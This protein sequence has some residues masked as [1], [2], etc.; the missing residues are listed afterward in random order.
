MQ[1][2][3]PLIPATALPELPVT[4]DT[5]IF[6]VLE[7]ELQVLLV[8]RGE[9]KFAGLWSLPG[10][11]V[12]PNEALDEAAI[13]EL[14]EATGVHDVYLEQ[15]YTFGDP[16][17]DTR[18][19]VVSVAYVALL[20]ADRC[21]LVPNELEAEARW[22]P[23]YELPDLAF[24]HPRMI[25]VAIDRVRTKLEYTT[26]G[27]QL[28]SATFT[29]GELQ[30]VYEVILDRELDKRN[31]RRRLQLLDLVESTGELRKEGPGRPALLHRFSHVNF[32][33]LRDR[34]IHTPF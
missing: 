26:I 34:G 18:G 24:D 2:P 23:A 17:R 1:A 11:F 5:V 30:R 19:R 9:K 8:E 20:A 25:E 15:L 32:V 10:G 21:P 7:Q 6:T 4:V 3:A 13:R 31:F 27:F 33:H 22:W 12:A 14:H 16:R 29:L 28:L